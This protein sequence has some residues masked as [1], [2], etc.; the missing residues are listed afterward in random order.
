MD[1]PKY[2]QPLT[3]ALE[4][5]LEASDKLA[6]VA[7]NFELDDKDVK[8]AQELTRARTQELKKQLEH[9]PLRIDVQLPSDND[10]GKSS[11]GSSVTGGS[12]S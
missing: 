3:K 1:K 11:K 10:D 4:A 5:F 6:S 2:V 8:Y 12:L 7:S 9:K